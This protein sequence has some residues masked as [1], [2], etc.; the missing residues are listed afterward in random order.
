MGLQSERAP[1][2]ADHHAAEARGFSQFARAPVRLSTWRSL[3]CLND[4][5][6]NMRISDLARGTRSRLI[7]ESF[8]PCIEEPR[9]P[10]ANH[11]Q[12]TTQL[13]RHGL[14]IQSLRARKN[15]SRATR[16]CRLAARAVRKRFQPLSL[17]FAQ[18]Q[19]LFRSPS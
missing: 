3:Q 1:D 8:Q 19:W 11:A 18:H 13:L 2:A 6:F 12:R 16:Q 7:I 9:A 15:Y 4:D 10:L 14:V 17:F 5:L